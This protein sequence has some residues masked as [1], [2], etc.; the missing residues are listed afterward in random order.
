MCM[1]SETLCA[2]L[3]YVRSSWNV[4]HTGGEHAK[5][6]HCANSDDSRPWLYCRRRA[7]G[8]GET[9][10]KLTLSVP[11]ITPFMWFY[12][13]R[14]AV[15]AIEHLRTLCSNEALPTWETARVALKAC[16]SACLRS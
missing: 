8:H 9:R 6:W 7:A 5:L 10:M 3:G 11:L 15:A 14:R 1:Q 16:H 4:M 12:C 2:L 13:S